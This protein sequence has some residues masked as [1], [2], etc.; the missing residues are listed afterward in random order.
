MTVS[1]DP[2]AAFTE[3][4]YAALCDVAEGALR[5]NPPETV[6]LPAELVHECY[7]KLQASQDLQVKGALH[8]R[9]L[10]ATMI[11]QLLVDRVRARS[12]LKR[13]G[14]WDRVSLHEGSDTSSE[15]EALDLLA[16]DEVLLRLAGL[17]SRQARIVELRFFGGL[18]IDEV[19]EALEI[20]PR[21]VDED[22]MLAKAW[23]RRA[24]A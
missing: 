15:L 16:L 1:H 23:L 18:T 20:A 11:R 14:A 19:A 5:R 7:L 3:T 4:V 22:W 17:D 2:H 12:A 21:T 6:I 8:F 9:A 10:A 13:G 24:L